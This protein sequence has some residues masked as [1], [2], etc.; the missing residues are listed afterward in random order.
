MDHER[1][2]GPGH[3]GGDLANQPQQAVQPVGPPGPAAYGDIRSPGFC[4]ISWLIRPRAAWIRAGLFA[5]PAYG[6][7]TVWATL[8]PQP[9]QVSDPEGWARFVGS[10]SYLVSHLVGTIGGTI[11][12]IF[13]TFALGAYLASSRSPRLALTGMTLAVA[14]H[15]L[16]VVPGAISAFAT[17]AIGRAY[18][19]GNTQV[20]ELEFPA[21]MT[22]I[23]A[24]ALVLALVGNV[25]LGVAVWRS[26]TLPRWAGALWIAATLIFYV[27]GA[28]LGM[29]TTGASLPTQPIGAALMALSGGWMAWAALR[30]RELVKANRITTRDGGP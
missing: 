28:V 20:M 25:L 17:P 13:G 11:L 30:H 12:A 27:F 23:V 1:R 14:G 4:A 18:L 6:I 10:S 9:D 5:L 2:T 16:F 21:L 29:A 15:A 26:G 7:L 19:A 3:G 8:E 22:A 24:F